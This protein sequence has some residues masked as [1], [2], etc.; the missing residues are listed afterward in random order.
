MIIIG[1]LLSLIGVMLYTKASVDSNHNI[2]V[3]GPAYFGGML[4]A[5]G[6]WATYSSRNPKAIDVYKGK[7]TLQITYKDNTPI[8]TTVVYK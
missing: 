3:T 5:F 4:V 7:T 1:I 6:I 2:K 8:D